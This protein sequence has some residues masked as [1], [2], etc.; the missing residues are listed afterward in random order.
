ME[1]KKKY[2]LHQYRGRAKPHNLKQLT[3]LSAMSSLDMTVQA[4]FQT[5]NTAEQMYS[6]NWRCG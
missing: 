2:E 5:W 6:L 3:P 1:E 4:L